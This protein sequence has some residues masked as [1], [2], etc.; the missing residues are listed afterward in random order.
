MLNEEDISAQDMFNLAVELYDAISNV[1]G[2]DEVTDKNNARGPYNEVLKTRFTRNASNVLDPAS[3]I[4]IHQ[5]KADFLP[6]LK[7]KFKA[8]FIKACASYAVDNVGEKNVKKLI[9]EDN[10]V[11]KFL[12]KFQHF[13]KDDN[14]MI[15]WKDANER[16]LLEFAKDFYEDSED[17]VVFTFNKNEPNKYAHILQVLSILYLKGLMKVIANDMFRGPSERTDFNAQEQSRTRRIQMEEV[18]RLGLSMLTF[19]G[20]NPSMDFVKYLKEFRV[21]KWRVVDNDD[22]GLSKDAV[23]LTKKLSDMSP[24]NILIVLKCING[25]PPKQLQD[26]IK[27]FSENYIPLGTEKKDQ[28]KAKSYAWIIV[29]LRSMYVLNDGNPPFNSKM[30][31]PLM[32]NKLSTSCEIINQMNKIEKVEKFIGKDG[33][34]YCNTIGVCTAN[35]SKPKS[36]KNKV[37]TPGNCSTKTMYLN[38]DAEIRY[39]IRNIHYKM[40]T[41]A[42]KTQTNEY[43]DVLFDQLNERPYLNKGKDL[44]T[45]LKDVFDNIIGVKRTNRTFNYRTQVDITTEDTE[46]ETEAESEAEAQAAAEAEAKAA[47]EAQAA[48]EA[49]AAAEGDTVSEAD[50]QSE[51]EAQ[52]TSPNVEM[53]QATPQRISRERD[54][55]QL[56][57][58]QKQK[59]PKVETS[60]QPGTTS[61]QPAN[62]VSDGDL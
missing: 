26:D 50:P 52:P 20:D 12:A 18:G 23:D 28:D 53:T 13:F 6:E 15:E 22:T 35:N 44:F 16:T 60:L 41:E 14:G 8:A 54:N 21:P 40:M 19:A 49:E 55:S 51:P 25:K 45:G 48:A 24:E 39:N 7:P 42:S 3:L 37:E 43:I 11:R 9:E 46:A 56:Q 31:A 4:Q 34:N 59:T 1:D 38:Q 29:L 36:R 2:D 27:K 62:Y 61:L 32:Y 30:H 47:A 10:D 5:R 17:N 58:E 57:D 33:K